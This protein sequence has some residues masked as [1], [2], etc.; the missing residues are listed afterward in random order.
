MNKR[1]FLVLCVFM[2]GMA[3]CL[4]NNQGTE[5]PEDELCPKG[6][7]KAG[8]Y[9]GHCGCDKEDV[10]NILTGRYT[11]DEQSDNPG[12]IVDLC[13]HDPNKTE[14]GICGCGFSDA[15]DGTGEIWCANLD[16]CPNDD[17]KLKP[18]ICGCG[19]PDDIDHETGLYECLKNNIDLC[20]GNPDKLTPGICGCD[21]SDDV[22]D[23]ELIGTIF[24][25]LP[26]CLT[27]QLDLCQDDP[28]KRL[29]GVCGC[30]VADVDT[31][32]DTVL[33]CNDA[34]PKDKL[35]WEDDGV[36]GCGIEDN[37]K[38]L[39]DADGDGVPNCIDICPENVYKSF[40]IKNVP[41]DQGK[42]SEDVE[43][44]VL[45]DG[46]P[47]CSRIYTVYETKPLCA[48]IIA[49]PDAL[50]DMRD[51]WNDG[52]YADLPQDKAVFILKED[53]DLGTSIAKL[54]DWTG[55]GTDTYPF[56]GIFLGEQHKVSATA[57][58]APL[59]LGSVETDAIGLFSVVEGKTKVLPAIIDYLQID[60]S[61]SGND[62]V[63]ILA[64]IVRGHAMI[65][66]IGVTGNVS[67]QNYVG[68]LVGSV[69][70][71]T[72]E[73][74]SSNATV[75][76]G[77]SAIGGLVGKLSQ[78]KVSRAFVSGNTAN[79]IGSDAS[80]DVGGFVG[81]AL[82]HSVIRDSYASGAVSGYVRTGGFAGTIT[83]ASSLINAFSFASVTCMH[84]PCA[85]LLAHISGA[86]VVKNVYAT[87]YV[88][89]DSLTVVSEENPD[90]P[91]NEETGGTDPQCSTENVAG[92][93]AEVCGEH[94]IEQFYAWSDAY[95]TSVPEVLREN[96]GKFTFKNLIATLDNG[97]YLKT[98]LN[99]NIHCDSKGICILDG[100]QYEP[101]NQIQFRLNNMSLAIPAFTS[102]KSVY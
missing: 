15:P 40:N 83:D 78:A 25:K 69:S 17:A 18:G 57:G 32:G 59:L 72:L 27:K 81:T 91:L 82:D 86:S 88:N 101:W 30:G 71:S 68:G 51:A 87:N 9:K 76:G 64:G 61:F 46:T 52:L 96:V 93:I 74:V 58:G 37:E 47:D 99:E 62:H 12:E 2:I 54:E 4:E 45:E 42:Y 22:Y 24:E 79:V 48:R 41:N 14:P 44:C 33:D 6:T 67:G 90:E 73:S 94:T 100:V 97:R 85:G 89:T 13:P 21:E 60:L 66:H 77:V 16:L 29:P 10:I 102:L 75:S 7:L 20:P 31:D 98:Q 35:K 23:Q 34:C 53:I 39:S 84:V 26:V 11:C 92:L 19:V 55:I 50:I 95:E 43:K 5:V 65:R 36:C 49:T 8:Q 80:V 56:S 63:G 3:G 38:H 1:S 70:N 28:N